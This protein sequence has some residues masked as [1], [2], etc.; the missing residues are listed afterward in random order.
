VDR[1]DGARMDIYNESLQPDPC[2]NARSA[3]GRVT[4]LRV[5]WKRLARGGDQGGATVEFVIAVP[6]LM[7]M[8]LF[9]VQ[10]AVWMHATHVAQAAATR[11]L[12]AAAAD[13]ASA[14][15]G[16]AAGQQTLAAIGSGVLKDPRVTVIRT[17]TD[18]RV[19]VVG[20][21]ATVVPGVRWTVRATAA[22]PVERFVPD[23][24]ASG[25]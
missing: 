4:R 2:C 16:Q 3:A 17:A 18:V 6:V 24:R 20:T 10:A 23:L 11:A 25:G 1:N 14:A 22:G 19:E 13:G 9:I 21:A 5:R 15:Q 7:L 8:I 12:D